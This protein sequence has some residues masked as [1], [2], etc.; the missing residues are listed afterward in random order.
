[1]QLLK[2]AQ[3]AEL[4]EYIV[5]LVDNFCDTYPEDSLKSMNMYRLELTPESYKLDIKTI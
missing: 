5:I 4:Y 2:M 1:M 3:L